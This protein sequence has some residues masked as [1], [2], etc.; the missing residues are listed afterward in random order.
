MSIDSPYSY[1]QYKKNADAEYCEQ[2]QFCSVS[3]RWCGR[4]PS[5]Q[6]VKVP[7]SFLD[8]PSELGV[9]G[10]YGAD[11]KMPLPHATWVQEP[12]IVN[13]VQVLDENGEP[14]DADS[15]EPAVFVS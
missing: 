11:W 3:S 1:F 8:S 5:N 15:L 14:R 9:S 13:S 2:C 12:L 10:L 4:L 7:R 6:A